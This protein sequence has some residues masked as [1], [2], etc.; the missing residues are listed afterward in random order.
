MKQYLKLL[1]SF[2]INIA[3]LSSPVN[4]Q[5]YKKI[6]EEIAAKE[7][8]N[9][10]FWNNMPVYPLTEYMI[11]KKLNLHYTEKILEI[12]EKDSLLYWICKNELGKDINDE[13]KKYLIGLL[14]ELELKN[15]PKESKM[16]IAKRIGKK[17]NLN[18][19]TVFKYNLFYHAIDK[20]ANYDIEI[21]K[22]I[23][24]GDVHISFEAVV[25]LSRWSKFEIS[26]IKDFLFQTTSD[27]TFIKYSDIRYELQWK[28]TFS[29]KKKSNKV[30]LPI[31][32]LPNYDPDAEITSLFLT[33]PSWI[34]TMARTQEKAGFSKA[35]F[36][37]KNNLKNK[38]YNL[39][40]TIDNILN[41]I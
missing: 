10:Y 25:E 23:L 38:L 3:M 22:F 4:K 18:H 35:S 31:K 2:D 36:E 26:L 9:I 34:G 40:E 21:A 15:N 16:T 39:K 37:A 6:E 12:K 19:G 41:I 11:C 24:C 27:H 20:I 14:F 17:N 29:S 32:K 28:Q 7:S 8:I 30:I 1:K 13:F 5:N 33:I